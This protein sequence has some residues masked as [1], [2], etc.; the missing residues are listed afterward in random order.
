MVRVV[1]EDAHAPGHAWAGRLVLLVGKPLVAIV[2]TVW[3]EVC[4]VMH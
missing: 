4:D 1:C 2:V 3:L